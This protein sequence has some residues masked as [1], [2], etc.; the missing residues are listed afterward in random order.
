MLQRTLSNGTVTEA[1]VRLQVA[2]DTNFRGASTFT[3]A[4]KASTMAPACTDCRTGERTCH[5]ERDRVLLF[6][7]FARVMFMSPDQNGWGPVHGK[8]VSDLV[9]AQDAEY[10]T[11]EARHALQECAATKWLVQDKVGGQTW[12]V[13][14]DPVPDDHPC[15]CRAVATLRPVCQLVFQLS[16]RQRQILSALLERTCTKSVALALQLT[17]STVRSHL[18]RAQLTTCCSD[19]PD[20]VKWAYAM[21]H[22]ISRDELI[23]AYLARRQG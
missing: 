16:S 21:R 23:A 15:C 22:A 3:P 17:D 2:K 7:A 1:E 13:H 18:A 11:A 5:C 8:H 20:L 19:L 4:S 6:D 9:K 10:V 14:F 12:L